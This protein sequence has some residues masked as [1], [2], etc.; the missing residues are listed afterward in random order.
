MPCE[1]LEAV[2]RLSDPELV[3]SLKTLAGRGRETTVELVAHLAELDTRDLYLRAGY[4]SLFVYC[5]DVLLLSEHE[6]YNRIEAARAARRYPGILEMLREGS[7][8]LTS[9]RLLGRHLTDENHARV[10]ES[11]RGRKKTEV[12]GIVAGLWPQPDAPPVVRRLPMRPVVVGAPAAS[13]SLAGGGGAPG[14]PVPPVTPAPLAPFPT[15]PAA[16]T[17]SLSPD[18]YKLQFTIGTQTLEKLRLAK[19]M[20]RHAIPTGDEAAI[21]DR[22]LT[23]LLAELARKKFAATEKPRPAPGTAPESRHVPAE[24]KRAV[25]LRDGGQCAFLGRDGRRCGERGFLEFHHVKPWVVGGEATVANVQLR[26]RRHNAYEA[27]LYFGDRPGDG[28]GLVKE[29]GATFLPVPE[30]VRSAR[31]PRGDSTT[32]PPP[33]AASARGRSGPGGT[34]CGPPRAGPGAGRFDLRRGGGGP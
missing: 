28:S 11:A 22:A 5:R 18:R 1:I 29:G 33:R 4:G 17:T 26:C 2:R 14:A 25:W 3:S 6:A 30:R 9:V 21:L 32:S 27:K 19:D 20:L 31:G 8:N 16:V 10:L 23:V 15:R 7:L 12:E 34:R 24:V 13:S